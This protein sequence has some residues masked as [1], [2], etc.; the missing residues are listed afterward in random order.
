MVLLPALATA[1]GATVAARWLDKR[2]AISTD[3]E[4]IR[5]MRQM[6]DFYMKLASEHGDDDWSFYHVLHSTY[7]TND[8]KEAFVF[9]DRSWTYG[10]LRGEIGRLAETFRS[11]GIGNR[12]VVG[13]YVNNSVEFI[14]SW[15]ALYKL[16][17]IPAPVNTAV[18]R[19]PFR[20]C[21]TISAAEYFI[22]TYELWDAAARSLGLADEADVGRLPGLKSVII[23]DYDSYPKS[24]TVPLINADAVLAQSTL[25]PF[26]PSMADF[27]KQ[28]RPKIGQG[29]A[30]CYLFTSGTTGMPKAAVWPAAYSLMTLANKR[31]PYMHDEPRRFY[32]CMPMFHGSA[33]FACLPGTFANSG[34]VILARRFSVSRFWHDCRHYNANSVLY[35]GEMIRYLVQAPPDP[36]FPDPKTMHNVKICYGLGLSPHAWKTLR[37]KFGIPWIIEY[38]SAS[39]APTSILNSNKSNDEGVGYVARWGPLMRSKW[40]GQDGLYILK[41]DPEMTEPIRNKAG[42]C[43]QADLGEKGEAIARIESPLRRSHDYV[44]ES[45]EEAT[46][47]KMLHDVFKKGDLFVRLGDS[48]SINKRGWVKFHDRLGDTFRAKGHNIST[49]EVEIAFTKHPRVLGA[50]VYAIP[51]N[52]FGYEGQLG[53]AA[54][55]L[56]SS[57]ADPTG[58]D[59]ATLLAELEQWLVEKGGLPTYG[60][61]RFVRVIVDEGEATTHD[62]GRRK[63][64]IPGAERVSII[65]KKLKTGLRREGFNMPPR[66][67]DRMYFIDREGNGFKPLTEEMKQLLLSGKA[68][69]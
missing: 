65:M 7:G 36:H 49:T 46:R 67:N 9:E 69:L 64:D 2:Y 33:A 35:I 47:K 26:V 61:P 55:S 44:G 29:D 45:G 56:K 4:Q 59:E 17:A 11:I 57:G 50:N 41:T 22:T 31:W 21:L 38:Y 12:T 60:V 15:F 52:E 1:A 30:S 42:F 10:E 48:L 53:C 68:K 18:T 34:T 5:G 62:E 19:D 63:G 58:T 27:P 28:D 8:L 51:M 66:C 24:T 25:P 32:I 54:I 23:Y 40:F 6:R 13:M 39:E 37:E 14:V 3:L 43:V 20:H 16:G